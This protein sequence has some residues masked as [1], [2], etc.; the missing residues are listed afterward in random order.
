MSEKEVNIACPYDSIEDYPNHIY[1]IEDVDGKITGILG[2]VV[3]YTRDYDEDGY[4]PPKYF[5]M[6]G[7]AA[8]MAEEFLDEEY[9]D[10]MPDLDEIDFDNVSIETIHLLKNPGQSI[11][12]DEYR[13]S[14]MSYLN[15][16]VIKK[17]TA[18]Q[19]INAFRQNNVK[20]IHRLIDQ[21]QRPPK[22]VYEMCAKFGTVE[23]MEIMKSSYIPLDKHFGET[24]VKLGRINM[25][26]WASKYTTLDPSTAN[27]RVTLNWLHQ[28]G[29]NLP[30]CVLSNA[31][32]NGNDDVV[33]WFK[34]FIE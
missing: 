28:K 17:I 18:K 15:I 19:I 24:V 30:S 2:A 4:M 31:I 6:D 32:K 34:S 23:M 3:P 10:W 26:E 1:N 22:R 20:L 27:D 8:E 14:K 9:P 25:L 5:I 11:T 29:Y 33:E 21:K 12:L 7:G 16:P 13:N